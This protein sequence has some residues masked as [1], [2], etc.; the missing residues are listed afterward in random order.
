LNRPTL[1]FIAT[2]MDLHKTDEK[3]LGTP[4]PEFTQSSTSTNLVKRHWKLYIWTSYAK[5]F[6]G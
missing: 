2:H 5:L 1:A 6:W 4:S 3:V